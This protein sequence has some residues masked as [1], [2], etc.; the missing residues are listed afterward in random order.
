MV[1]STKKKYKQGK[2]VRKCLAWR[3]GCCLRFGVK[4]GLTEKVTSEHGPEGR[5]G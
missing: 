2:E 3:E 5:R 4:E 1:I